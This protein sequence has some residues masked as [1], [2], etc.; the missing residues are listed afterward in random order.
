M[1]VVRE[2]TY[3]SINVPHYKTNDII[4]FY[5][6]LKQ[7]KFILFLN[8]KNYG[9]ILKKSKF[10]KGIYSFG[11]NSKEKNNSVQ[12]LDYNNIWFE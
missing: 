8:N 6:N 12:V 1:Y 5:V 9:N 2:N 11:W 3:E 7:N 4:D 10:E